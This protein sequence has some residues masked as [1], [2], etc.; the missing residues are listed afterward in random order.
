MNTKIYK[1]PIPIIFLDTFFFIDLIKNRHQKVKSP[2]YQ[3]QENL[4]NIIKDLTKQKK[5]LC[6][7]GDQEEEYELGS[8]YTNEI[9]KEQSLLSYGISTTY[10]WG[11]QRHQTHTA[12]RAYINGD[13]TVLYDYNSLFSTNP[14]KELEQALSNEFIVSVISNP[15]NDTLS[16]RRKTKK[17]L[18]LEFE[19]LRQEKISIGT[20]FKKAVSDEKLAI[21]NV[22]N[23][24]FKK[25]FPKMLNNQPLTEED[26]N[27]WMTIG[28]LLSPFSHYANKEATISDIVKFIM[29]DYYQTIPYLDI[30]SNLY[31]SLLTQ[32]NIVKDGDNFDFEQA[33]QM[34]PFA[35]Y[36]LTD[37]SLKHRLITNPLAYDKKFGVKIYSIKEINI[38]VDD[39]L[40]LK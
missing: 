39:I 36:Y 20:N 13:K 38:L 14:I 40:K 10:H 15:K 22:I 26:L 35:D 16:K 24:T 12:M 29:S 33:S 2:Y 37:C 7:Q 6:P 4:I 11:V 31:G 1:P 18:A 30:Q 5:L 32:K 3:E 21:I 9:K 23:Y 28:D 34:I 25:T 8:L 27:G 19:R 17:E